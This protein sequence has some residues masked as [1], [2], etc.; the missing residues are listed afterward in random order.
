MAEYIINN[1]IKERKEDR[2]ESVILNIENLDARVCLLS[3]ESFKMPMYWGLPEELK[4]NLK[5]NIEELC[6]LIIEYKFKLER[7]KALS[8][9]ESSEDDE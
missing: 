4:K 9:D 7:H 1:V 8:K 5:R 2:V 3:G 6:S